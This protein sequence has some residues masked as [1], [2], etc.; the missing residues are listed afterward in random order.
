MRVIVM[1]GSIAGLTAGLL[2]MSDGHDV[3]VLDRGRD[4]CPAGPAEAWA[5]W[6][7]LQQPHACLP[8]LR[9]LLQRHL[10]HVYTALLQAGAL[11]LAT[12]S[13]GIAV[14]CRRTT[15]EFA[16][17]RSCQAAGLPIQHATTVTGLD[18]S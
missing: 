6:P 15:I 12:P 5:C 2:A 16:L 8:G 11:E 1:G 9:D 10:P 17:R 4:L 13:G 14:G 7:R 18:T 3:T